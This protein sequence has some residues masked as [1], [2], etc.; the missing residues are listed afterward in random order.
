LST[1]QTIFLKQPLL[2][3]QIIACVHF[4]DLP[5]EKDAFAGMQSSKVMCPIAGDGI[6]F[7]LP[8]KKESK[9]SPLQERNYLDLLVEA[10]AAGSR[11]FD[12]LSK[13]RP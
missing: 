7:C 4:F 11:A 8:H 13:F 9:K 12:T 6:F 5:S 2:R 3:E 1:T 10:R